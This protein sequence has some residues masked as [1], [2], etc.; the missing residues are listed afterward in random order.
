MRIREVSWR[1]RGLQRQVVRGS[2]MAEAGHRTTESR[3]LF[4][5]EPGSWPAGTVY[6][7]GP[8]EASRE[9]EIPLGSFRPMRAGVRSP[10]PFVLTGLAECGR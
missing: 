7:T 4:G 5:F 6:D 1:F 3:V 10:L 9:S 2:A 8:W